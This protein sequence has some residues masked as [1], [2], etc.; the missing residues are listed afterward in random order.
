M[1]SSRGAGALTTVGLPESLTAIGAGFF[2]NS[3]I[4]YLIVPAGI[5]SIDASAFTDCNALA[6]LD[7][8]RTS[9][10]DG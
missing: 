10:E 1:K 9:I 2:S 5:T 7:L 6:I 8:S 4:N 3:G